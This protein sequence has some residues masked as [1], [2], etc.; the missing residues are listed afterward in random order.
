MKADKHQT[1]DSTTK[2]SCF[3]K[4]DE[5]FVKE[6]DVFVFGKILEVSSFRIVEH[7]RLVC[8]NFGS[9]TRFIP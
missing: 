6:N 2:E 3:R 9:F 8:E 7:F 1:P 4:G 5:V